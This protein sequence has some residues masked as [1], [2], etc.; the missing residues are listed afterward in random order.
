MQLEQ[1]FF[2]SKQGLGCTFEL[3]TLQSK[4]KNRRMARPRELK[5]EI[6]GDGVKGYIGQGHQ[7]FFFSPIRFVQYI[8]STSTNFRN[9][10]SE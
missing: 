10:G 3:C 7:S 5:L 2:D 4:L 9:Y 1:H 6:N 8:L